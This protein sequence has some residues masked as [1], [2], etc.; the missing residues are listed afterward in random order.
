MKRMIALFFVIA[1][2]VGVAGAASLVVQSN[3]GEKK[4]YHIT[5][6]VKGTNI[7]F[8]KSV[9]EGAQA[10][11][12]AYNVTVSMIGPADEKDYMQQIE[13]MK[14]TIEQKPDAI[15]LA[16]GDYH[17]L[18][19]P[20]QDAIDA[21][22]PV[23]M[24]DSD[25]D[26]S[27]TVAYV[28][29]DNVKLGTTLAQKLCESMQES[30]GEVGV[31]SFVKESYPAMQ[32]EKGFRQ[33]MHSVPRFTVLETAYG[34]SD[35]T[36]TEKLTE[37]MIAE[38][39]NISAIAAL[40]AESCKGAALALSKLERRDIQLFGID[41]MPDEAMYME[42]GLL[43]LALLQNPYQMGYYSV[44]TACQYLNGETVHDRYTDIYTIDI[45]S[46]FD[47]QYQQ[48]IFPFNS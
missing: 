46:L 35:V 44:E 31:V 8:W 20:V 33:A 34:D 43:K 23:V 1:V 17:I 28:G 15:I 42:E 6:I 4:E 9:N 12:S 39:P 21:G 47:D 45:H 27:Q 41:C 16:A 11:A 32:R 36:K 38:H 24:V 48:L 22:I 10:A 18:A 13:L 19:D 30:S 14:T 5:L 7:E 26:N 3:T 25:V 40:N 37:Q 2:F 29:T